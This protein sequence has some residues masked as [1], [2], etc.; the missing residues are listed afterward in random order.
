MWPTNALQKL[1]G[2]ILGFLRKETHSFNLGDN[3]SSLSH[4]QLQ[5]CVALNKKQECPNE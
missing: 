5:F 4:T 1:A 2:H 3:A